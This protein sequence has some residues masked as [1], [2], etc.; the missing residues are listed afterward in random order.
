MDK[1]QQ[2]QE[3]EYQ[4]PYH[5]LAHYQNYFTQTYNW[6]FG[7]SYVS[8]LEF[9]INQLA[10]LK[11]Q[12]LADVGCG[13]GRLVK[14]LAYRFPQRKIVGI[15]YSPTAIKLAQALNP[16]L[17]FLKQDITDKNFNQQY[18]VLTLIEVLE[19]IPL[20]QIK[21]FITALVKLLKP[22]G[23]L[24]IT[25]PHQNKPLQQ[26]HYQHFT[27][28]KLEKIFNKQFKI[29]KITYFENR[30][31]K[32]AGLIHLL[33]TNKFFILNYQPLKN[34]LYWLYKKHCF[35]AQEDS[36]GRVFMLLQKK[37]QA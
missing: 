13:D 22:K 25:V 5:Y 29:K 34:F 23:Y 18:E 1:T 26:K 32:L 30:K 24:L 35:D 8:T 11:W 21:K 3:T 27:T 17:N 9:L 33:L 36:C 37:A 2:K 14:E 6:P 15:D 31:V 20:Q 10:Q 28:S 4:F 19:H 7:I 16:N 12:S